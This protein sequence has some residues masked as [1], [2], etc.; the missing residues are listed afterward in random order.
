MTAARRSGAWLWLLAALA[1]TLD[2]VA[3]VLALAGRAG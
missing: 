3:L 1:L 2:G